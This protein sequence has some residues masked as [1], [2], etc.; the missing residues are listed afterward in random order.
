MRVRALASRAALVA[1]L[2]RAN[3]VDPP[4][5]KMNKLAER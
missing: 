3:R 4:A 1:A 5:L 2:A